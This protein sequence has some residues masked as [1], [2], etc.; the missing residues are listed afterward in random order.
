V[1]D[2]LQ[3]PAPA[4]EKH[5]TRTGIMLAILPT[6]SAALA[7]VPGLVLTQKDNARRAFRAVVTIGM[8][9]ALDV[10]LHPN[11]IFAECGVALTNELKERAEV[12][13]EQGATMPSPV[14][15][16]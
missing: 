5:L 15:P 6:V 11:E 16:S 7:A 14:L 8:K 1:S 9:L 2:L 10:G 4:P 3:I 13:K 12:A